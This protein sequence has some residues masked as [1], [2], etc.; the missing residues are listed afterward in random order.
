MP[1]QSLRPTMSCRASMTCCEVAGA[2]ATCLQVAAASATS[3]EVAVPF[4][5][6]LEVVLSWHPSRL[7]SVIVLSLALCQSEGGTINFGCVDRHG[8]RS[9]AMLIWPSKVDKIDK[10]SLYFPIAIPLSF[11]PLCFTSSFTLVDIR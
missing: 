9:Y 6:R 4:A 1:L 2:L 5:T 11:F 7:A 10:I 8:S 3:Y